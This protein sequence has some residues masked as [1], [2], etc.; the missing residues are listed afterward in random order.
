MS[1]GKIIALV[2][3][4][5][6]AVLA[7]TQAGTTAGIWAT[8]I[9]LILVV[10]HTLEMLFFFKACQRAG[11]SLAGHLFNVFLFGVVHMQEVKAAQGDTGTA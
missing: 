6:L 4:A 11:G 9:I 3:Y 7:L 1:K 5:V 2:V 8:R 10:A